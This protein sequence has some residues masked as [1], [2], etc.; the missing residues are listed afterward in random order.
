MSRWYDR[1]LLLLT[2]ARLGPD[3]VDPRLADA[4]PADATL[5]GIHAERLLS[6]PVLHLAFDRVARKLAATWEAS[7]PHDVQGRERCY[8]QRHALELVKRELMSI[9]GDK[10]IIE[11]EHKA[12]Q[13]AE[14]RQRQP[15][16]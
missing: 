5:L 3:M 10:K 16:A 1:F 7:A 9:L 15:T 12:K 11:A 14:E 8:D 13:A 2:G 4:A 6:D